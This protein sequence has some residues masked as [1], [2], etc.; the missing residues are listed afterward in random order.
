[1]GSVSPSLKKMAEKCI[2]FEAISKNTLM[3]N[4]IKV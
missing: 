2:F 4:I 3:Q 1:M